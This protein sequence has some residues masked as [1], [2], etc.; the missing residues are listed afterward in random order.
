MM[1]EDDCDVSEN[2]QEDE[3]EKSVEE[4]PSSGETVQDEACCI[5]KLSLAEQEGDKEEGSRN[6]ENDN[7]DELKT[8]QGTENTRFTS[9]KQC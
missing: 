6:Q 9:V 7:Q 8:P 2:E 4:Q 1:D 3:A 5:N